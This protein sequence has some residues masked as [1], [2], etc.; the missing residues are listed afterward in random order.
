VVKFQSWQTVLQYGASALLQKGDHPRFQQVL[1]FTL[2]LDFMP[3]GGSAS[4]GR[5]RRLAVLRQ[6]AGRRAEAPAARPTPCRSPSW[7]SATS[8]GLLRLFD[9]FRILAGSRR[10]LDRA[11]DRLRH[12]ALPCTRRW[13]SIWPPGRREP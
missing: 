4:A 8:L 12:R 6:P 13:K 5:H 10:Q 11:P 2:L 7:I 9:R 1:R 3:R